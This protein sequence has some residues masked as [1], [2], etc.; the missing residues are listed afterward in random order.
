M[1]TV[2]VV[3]PPFSWVCSY[4]YRR[5]LPSSAEPIGVSYDKEHFSRHLLNNCRACSGHN[6]HFQLFGLLEE[7]GI[8]LFFNGVNFCRGN[9][10]NCG[11]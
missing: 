5:L 11:L 10:R 2:K 9:S 4:I 3:L 1:T 8:A 6:G 7:V